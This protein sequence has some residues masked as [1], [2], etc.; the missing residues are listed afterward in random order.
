MNR[1]TRLSLGI[2]LLAINLALCRFPLLGF[3]LFRL[4]RQLG[5][6]WL[7]HFLRTLS[8]FWNLC[9]YRLRLDHWNRL[10]RRLDCWRRVYRGHGNCL[11]YTSDAADEED[12]V[13][14]GGRR[15]IKKKKN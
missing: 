15:I 10:N 14:L 1:A 2:T 9:E 6:I 4:L 5:L 13:D 7:L 8:L 12:S 3:L 11:L